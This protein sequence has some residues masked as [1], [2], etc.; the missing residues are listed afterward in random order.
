MKYIKQK[1]HRGVVVDYKCILMEAQ[2]GKRKYFE[3]E[4][5]YGLLGF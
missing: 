5:K 3:D 1:M 4:E 2:K